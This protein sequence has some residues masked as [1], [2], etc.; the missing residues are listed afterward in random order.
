MLLALTSLVCSAAFAQRSGVR[1]VAT[2]RQLHDAMITPASEV[3]F[4]TG[5]KP[6]ASDEEWT[7]VRHAAIALA[8]SGNLLMIGSRARDRNKWMKMSRAM[9]DAAGASLRAVEARDLKALA[10]ASDRIVVAC[11]TCHEPYRDGG[12][13]MPVN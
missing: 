7:A 11:E 4:S 8:E 3:V 1:A 13:K 9:V 5:V 6:P 10:R 2:V 12:R